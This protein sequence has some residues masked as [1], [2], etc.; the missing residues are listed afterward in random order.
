MPVAGFTV[1]MKE[2]F[3]EI[4]NPK[5]IEQNNLKA[6]LEVLPPSEKKGYSDSST[7]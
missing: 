4:A 3:K 5:E 2:R 1:F 6:N 7:H